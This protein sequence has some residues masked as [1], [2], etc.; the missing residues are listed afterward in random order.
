MK[1]IQI[2]TN[3]ALKNMPSHSVLIIGGGGYLGNFVAR[4][5]IK[6]K[7][8]FSRVA[9]LVEASK[10]SKFSSIQAE[11]ME[12]TVGSF[13]DPKSFNGLLPTSDQRNLPR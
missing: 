8:S 7:G 10:A 5:F 1:T 12:I 11:G 9:I 3:R 13:N 4:A 6:Q 2:I